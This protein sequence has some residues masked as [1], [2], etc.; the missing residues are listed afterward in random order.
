MAA[1]RRAGARGPFTALDVEGPWSRHHVAHHLA[2][3]AKRGKVRV[4][5]PAV[6]GR[7]GSPTVYALC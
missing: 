3:L 7:Y 1:I 5:T 6:M 4:V 2:V